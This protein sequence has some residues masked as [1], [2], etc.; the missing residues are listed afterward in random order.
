MIEYHDLT[1]S[2]AMV[3]LLPRVGGDTL[4]LQLLHDTRGD[5]PGYYASG[6][7]SYQLPRPASGYASYQLPRPLS[8]VVR[9]RINTSNLGGSRQFV[10]RNE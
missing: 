2:L 10:V 8:P 1:H 9:V 7:A 3:A 5:A 4:D 6:Y